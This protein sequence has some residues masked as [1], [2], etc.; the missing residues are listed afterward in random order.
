MA[1]DVQ[2]DVEHALQ[3]GGVDAASDT[4]RASSALENAAGQLVDPEVRVR[5]RVAREKS[6]VAIH[7]A[8][9]L[10]LEAHAG[11]AVDDLA[12]HYVE[13]VLAKEEF[14]VDAVE[15]FLLALDRA[16][17]GLEHAGGDSYDLAQHARAHLQTIIDAGDAAENVD[18]VYAVAAATVQGDSGDWPC[19]EA[20]TR[21][22]MKL[23][24]RHAKRGEFKQLE[25]LLQRI[26]AA[27]RDAGVAALAQ[28]VQRQLVTCQLNGD[29]GDQPELKVLGALLSKVRMQG[30]LQKLYPATESDTSSEEPGAEAT[31]SA[32]PALPVV[33]PA[34]SWGE[35]LPLGF[36]L[37][38][39]MAQE[40]GPYLAGRAAGAVATTQL[41]QALFEAGGDATTP[42]IVLYGMTSVLAL[43]N[44]FYFDARLR[45]RQRSEMPHRPT[46]MPLRKPPELRS[47][48]FIKAFTLASTLL[49]PPAFFLFGVAIHGSA[50]GAGLT[51][52]NA[53]VGANTT[54]CE[55]HLPV[56]GTLVAYAASWALAPLQLFLTG[57]LARL[58]REAAQRALQSPATSPITLVYKLP[59]GEIH[60]LSDN[61]VFRL[62]LLRDSKYVG[63]SVGFNFGLKYALPSLHA[64]FDKALCY[65][66]ALL[67]VDLA[68]PLGGALTE[69]LDA[70][71][72]A[73]AM[74]LVARFPEAFGLDPQLAPYVTAV[75][76]EQKGPFQ[77]C[78]A[79][80]HDIELGTSTRWWTQRTASDV[81]ASL[82]W[83]AREL[84]SESMAKVMEF[85]GAV[86]NGVVG[87]RRGNWG[88][89]LK[90]P[91]GTPIPR[92]L[93]SFVASPRRPWERGAQTVRVLK[94]MESALEQGLYD[95]PV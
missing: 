5:A 34:T 10:L 6:C 54:D 52:A 85:V 19:T 71:I 77:D 24:T 80:L 63:A 51:Q 23:A 17:T 28:W 1:Q 87:A 67:G 62:Y 38:L 92:G 45:N 73:V 36:R 91:H 35:Y 41:V 69:A 70:V 66:R 72:P 25:P 59:N 56:D 90:D 30:V 86:M 8:I 65:A 31:P 16:V 78:M 27:H 64:A 26:V 7:R 89:Y 15:P 60:K 76:S 48:R 88:A 84:G 32:F 21:Q 81:P 74:L 46:F 29:T 4:Q 12:R 75:Y 3:S 42:A 55:Y 79:T 33:P 40:G 43:F 20:E 47:V 58:G 57:D 39:A 61:D 94:L 82:A 37:L 49:V 50:D 68:N 93:G 18:R 44:E 95:T 53:T 2:V 13:S 14:G 83:M 11:V 22:L 9:E